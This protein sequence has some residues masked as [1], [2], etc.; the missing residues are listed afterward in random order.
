MP[1]VID[2]LHYR[3]VD[4]ST[5]KELCARQGFIKFPT[6][7]VAV[8]IDLNVLPETVHVLSKTGTSGQCLKQGVHI[9]CVGAIR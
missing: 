7:I 6:F 9:A 8:L 4:V 1:R 5:V 2:H 3:V